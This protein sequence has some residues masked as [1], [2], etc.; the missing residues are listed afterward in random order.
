M[1]TFFQ[2]NLHNSSWFAVNFVYNEQFQTALKT[3][4]NF[5]SLV[6]GA[7][8][9]DRMAYLLEYRSIWYTIYWST[10]R[11]WYTIYWSAVRIWYTIYWSTIR[12]WYTIYW[13]AVRIWYT[14]YW[15]TVGS[16]TLF[17]GVPYGSV[18]L[19]IGVPYGSGT[20]FIG[21]PY[22]SGTLFIPWLQPFIL[23]RIWKCKMSHFTF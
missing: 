20:L 22:G 13:S 5:S 19:F 12:I 8:G 3:G 11:I 21:V 2:F 9:T 17:I 6:S 16:G 7:W 23:L 4:E 10:I 15:S 18:T 1:W 14:I